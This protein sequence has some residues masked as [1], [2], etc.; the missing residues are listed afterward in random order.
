M[1]VTTVLGSNYFATCSDSQEGVDKGVLVWLIFLMVTFALALS[2]CIRLQV[3][4]II[5]GIEIEEVVI[6]V[7]SRCNPVQNTIFRALLPAIR[8][9]TL[10]GRLV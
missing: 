9:P 10:A 8:K 4:T 2:C 5:A 7:L 1:C 3:A 6:R